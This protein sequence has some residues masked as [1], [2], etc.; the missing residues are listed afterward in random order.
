MSAPTEADPLQVRG[1]SPRFVEHSG[2]RVVL[3]LPGAHRL[4]QQKRA[5]VR[6]LMFVNVVEN[7]LAAWHPAN[8]STSVRVPGVPA[9]EWSTRSPS[10]CS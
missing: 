2:P 3:D 9:L 8:A 10:S 1:H 7:Q 6:R 5:R 4:R